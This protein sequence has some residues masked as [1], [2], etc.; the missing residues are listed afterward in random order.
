MELG[1]TALE[2]CKVPC[3]AWAFRCGVQAGVV[4]CVQVANAASMC[5]AEA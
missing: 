4:P 2:A 1:A 3:Q 5:T